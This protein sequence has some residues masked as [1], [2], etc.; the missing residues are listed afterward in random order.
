[1]Y[2]VY[3][4][5]NIEFNNSS[6]DDIIGVAQ[7]QTEIDTI[8]RNYKRLDKWGHQHDSFFS[9]EFE[10]EYLTGEVKVDLPP[11]K[12]SIKWYHCADGKLI[13]PIDLWW[14]K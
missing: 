2:L 4:R 14:T 3:V 6:R 12:S 7:N 8:I 10:N 13:E 11:F 5:V 9:M 1:M